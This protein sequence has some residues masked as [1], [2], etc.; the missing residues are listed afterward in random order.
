MGFGS[1]ERSDQDMLKQQNDVLLRELSEMQTRFDANMNKLR[2]D[3]ERIVAAAVVHAPY[4]SPLQSH[5]PNI[6]QPPEDTG[7]TSGNLFAMRYR[8]DSTRSSASRPKYQPAEEVGDAKHQIEWI[9][10]SSPY[11]PV[12]T[13]ANGF[14]TFWEDSLWTLVDGADAVLF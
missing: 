14:D 10:E 8:N 13:E 7:E 6:P 3:T 5:V 9:A 11:D 2:S 1:T 4:D 12:A